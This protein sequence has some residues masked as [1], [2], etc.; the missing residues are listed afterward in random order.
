MTNLEKKIFACNGYRHPF[1][2]TQNFSYYAY[3]NKPTEPPPPGYE[4]KWMRTN[5]GWRWVRVKSDNPVT[6]MKEN[7][8]EALKALVSAGVE[9]GTSSKAISEVAKSVI[10]VV[11]SPKAEGKA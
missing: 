2:K 3:K 11:A 1:D 7:G 10:D 8:A 9:P 4:Y 5:V 6:A